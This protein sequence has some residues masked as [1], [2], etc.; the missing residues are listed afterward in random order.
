MISICFSI[1]SSYID[2]DLIDLL[3]QLPVKVLFL[4]KIVLPYFYNQFWSE[5]IDIIDDWSN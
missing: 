2:L 3:P 4:L 5:I 1:C